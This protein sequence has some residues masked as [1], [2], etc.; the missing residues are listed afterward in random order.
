MSNIITRAIRRRRSALRRGDTRGAASA[1][2]VVQ[3]LR[4]A[5]LS[6]TVTFD[7]VPISRG[8]ARV[9]QDARDHGVRFL[10]LS[11]D[12]RLGVAERFGHS[13]QAKLYACWMARKP[14][15]NPANPPGRSTHELRSDGVAYRG[16]VGRRLAYWQMGLDIDPSSDLYVWLNSHGYHV[17]RPYA[18]KSEYHHLNFVT[19]PRRNYHRRHRGA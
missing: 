18:A 16:P 14:G 11:A 2:R 3:R 9:L 1:L 5:S 7:G 19:N 4:S 17:R 8:L 13:S 10:L 15:C 6:H 12:R